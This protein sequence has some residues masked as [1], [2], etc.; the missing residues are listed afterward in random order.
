MS[1]HNQI[2]PDKATLYRLYVVERK[3]SNEIAPIFNY[4]SNKS[5][6]NWLHEYGIP[7]RTLSEAQVKKIQIE[8][9]VLRQL[10]I[11][12]KMSTSAI[13][14]L[15][16]C[17]NEAIRRLLMNKRIERRK[18]TTNFGGWNKGQTKETNESIKNAADRL[19]VKRKEWY[20]T[21]K[22]IHHN[23]DKTLSK[24]TKQKI[25][26]SLTGRYR[27]PDNRNWKGGSLNAYGLWK[28]Q[29]IQSLDYRIFRLYIYERDEYT[30]QICINK[31]KGD[32]EV[33]HIKPV[34]YCPD[35]IMTESNCITLCKRCHGYCKKEAPSLGPLG[36]GG[37]FAI[38]EAARCGF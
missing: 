17:K 27:G 20:E 31:S 3:T 33:H 6:I 9:S 13:A 2:R 36:G 11:D 5:I 4:K 28:K 37:I 10:Y 18:K 24:T 26:K 34:F 32:I 25:S 21:G 14:N 19:S 1:E 15:F 12:K 16:G 35:L 30:C 22:L 29:I 38:L 8:D 7:V 23:K